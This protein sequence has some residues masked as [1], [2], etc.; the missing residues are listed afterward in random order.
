MRILKM[1]QDA[2]DIPMVKA[3]KARIRVLSDRAAA[4]QLVGD[5]ARREEAA[6]ALKVVTDMLNEELNSGE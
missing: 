5:E 3:L 1:N 6:T 4:A 2:L